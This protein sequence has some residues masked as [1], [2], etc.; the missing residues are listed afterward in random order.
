M[1]VYFYGVHGF[2]RRFACGFRVCRAKLYVTMGAGHFFGVAGNF[3]VGD[4]ASDAFL[5][6]DGQLFHPVNGQANAEYDS[7]NRCR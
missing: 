6:K 2:L 7:V 1:K 3:N 4:Y 5:T